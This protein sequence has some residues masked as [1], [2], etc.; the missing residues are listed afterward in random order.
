MPPKKRARVQKDAE[1]ENLV[2]QE[3]IERNTELGRGRAEG[4]TE[5]GER[6]KLLKDRVAHGDTEAM[7]SLAECFALGRDIEQNRSQAE[8]LV[9]ESAK[10]GNKDA[11]SL[12]RL[13]KSGER[14]KQW[15]CLVC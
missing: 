7:L 15:T 4:Q 8:A 6:V 9:S 10:K 1:R 3:I 11:K 14:K 12:V 5:E 13:I 2:T